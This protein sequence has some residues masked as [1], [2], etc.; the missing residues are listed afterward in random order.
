MSSL[1]HAFDISLKK[2]R[3]QSGSLCSREKW[4]GSARLEGELAHLETTVAEERCREVAEA[5]RLLQEALQKR[6]RNLDDIECK[7]KE[8]AASKAATAAIQAVREALKDNR[9][10]VVG[11]VDEAVQDSISQ[12]S[13]MFMDKFLELF[14][15]AYFWTSGFYLHTGKI[16]QTCPWSG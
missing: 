12:M 8:I 13:V 7:Q 14:P 1:A 5:N 6:K 4:Q 9:Q 16:G 10:T 3:I 2:K 11:R 15:H